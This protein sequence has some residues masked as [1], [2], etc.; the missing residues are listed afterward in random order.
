MTFFLNKLVQESFPLHPNCL[1]VQRFNFNLSFQTWS[2]FSKRERKKTYSNFQQL[3]LVEIF[4][5]KKFSS[6]QV[7][8]SMQVK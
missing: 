4:G 6:A 7:F 5:K 8:I 1:M 2:I 3:L